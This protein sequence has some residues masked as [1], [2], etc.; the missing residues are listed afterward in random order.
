MNLEF[1]ENKHYSKKLE[2][3]TLGACFLEK[4]AFS[5]L[6]GRLEEKM[7][8]QEGSKLVFQALNALHTNGY[9][10][11][12]LT[13]LDHITN[14]LKIENINGDNVAYYLS[15][16][17]DSV[18]SSAHLE[19][20]CLIIK[21]MYM[22]RE[23]MKITS[24]AVYQD[25][26]VE[27][28]IAQLQKAIQNLNSGDYEKDWSDTTDLML[29]LTNHQ[30]ETLKNPDSVIKTGI[31]RLDKVGQCFHPGQLIIFGARPS[32]GKSAFMGQIAIGMAKKRKTVG[33]ISLEMSNNEIAA[34]IAS[35]DSGIPFNNIFNGLYSDEHQRQ[36]F[37]RTIGN[38][39]SEL[40]IYVSEATR[41]N[42]GD[43][44]AKADKL[45]IKHGLDILFIDYLQ[46]ISA[47]QPKNKLREQVIA[48]ITRDCK[49]MAK[50]LNIPVV[51]L[52]QLNREST[53][54]SGDARYPQLSDLRE[55]GAIEQDADIVMFLHRDYL[56][57]IEADA[58]GNSTIN[59]ADLIVRKW[60]NGESNIKIP[61]LFDG[62]TMTF[63]FREQKE[64]KSF[65]PVGTNNYDDNPF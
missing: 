64:E 50:E 63:D 23:L 18:T 4:T 22:Q 41:V 2:S 20:H 59:K 9:P 27:D 44:R 53:K 39:T 13:A 42:T 11:D 14:V 33:I 7:F 65:Q 26:D 38:S 49:I 12:L 52:C 43:I 28:Q 1:T 32:A 55:S 24:E 56:M 21:R 46:L 17:A 45:K 48:D 6:R 62:P 34:R 15:K 40:P 31:P 35:L 47:D 57:G 16:L 61:I 10:I 36:H 29:G 51:L 60:R 5:S 37:H 8:Y 19:S 58:N 54:R 3:T 25:G 30:D